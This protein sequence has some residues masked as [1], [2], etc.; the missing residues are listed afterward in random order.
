MSTRVR[1]IDGNND[2]TFG[3]GRN[4][5]KFDNTAVAQ[6]IK[7][8]LQSFLGDC[9]FAINEGIDWFNLLGSKDQRA[10]TLSIATTIL[11]TQDVTGLLELNLTLNRENR[12]ITIQYE[13]ST[14]YTTISNQ[15]TVGIPEL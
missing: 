14:V 4:N 2:W 8:R 6:N 9:F 5:Y 1:A 13:V 10:L 11:N 12:L 3:K 7:T 15:V